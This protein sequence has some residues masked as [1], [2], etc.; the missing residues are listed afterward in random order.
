MLFLSGAINWSN[1]LKKEKQPRCKIKLQSINQKKE[2][3]EN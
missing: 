2:L 3:N 1:L